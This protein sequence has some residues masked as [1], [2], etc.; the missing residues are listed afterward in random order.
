MM[1]SRAFQSRRINLLLAGMLFL[2]AAMG[3]SPMTAQSAVQAKS[4]AANPGNANQ[5]VL[6]ETDQYRL[7][8]V[9]VKFGALLGMQPETAANV[10]TIFNILVLVVG[11]G[12]GIKKTLPKAFLKRTTDIQKHLIDARTVTEEATAR[13]N[14]VEDRLSKLDEQIAAMKTQADADSKRD[15][16]RIQARLEEEKQGIIAAAEAEIH[17]A[18]SL[19]RREIQR[20]AAELAIENASQKLNVTAEI[21]RMLLANFAQNLGDGSKN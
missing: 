20:Y 12:Y 4:P 19:A 13:L 16:L 2:M 9:V 1:S 11:V 18:T 6:N 8:P 7:S 10:F 3:C 21:D 14:S 15:E 5:T 17:S